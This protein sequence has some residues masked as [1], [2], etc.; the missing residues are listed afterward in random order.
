M[1]EETN[2]PSAFTRR[3]VSGA[4][5]GLRFPHL[6]SILRDLP[7]VGWFEALTDNYFGPDGEA[8]RSLEKV[9]EHYP[10]TMHSVG[11]S[12]GSVEPIDWDYVGRIRTLADRMEPDWISEHL[13]WTTAHGVHFHDLL[14]LPYTEETIHHVADR[15]R[16]VQDFLGRQLLIENVSSY[17]AYEQSTL[18]EWDFI[19]AIAE[20][21]DCRIL[22]DVNNTYVTQVN[23]GIDGAEYIRGIPPERVGEMHL[24]GGEEREGYLLDSHSRPVADEVWRLF[25]VAVAHCGSVPSLIEWDNDIPA[26]DVLHD[27]MRKADRF[28]GE[29][30]RVGTRTLAES[31]Q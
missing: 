2:E 6:E 19:A 16:D 20:E 29:E 18:T 22:L 30:S 21:A 12:I 15:L 3:S 28:L 17:L 5:I 23:H 8:L 14:P 25:E 9:R 4:G 1:P 10:I 7:E 26:F 11:M 27:E 13:C 31:I 24:A